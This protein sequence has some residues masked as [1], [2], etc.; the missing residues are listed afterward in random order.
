MFC[1]RK[2]SVTFNAKRKDTKLKQ[3][4]AKK[5]KVPWNKG[6]HM[7]KGKEH[8]RGTLGK[9]LP[10]KVVSEETK[11]KMRVVTK[12][13]WKEQGFRERMTGENANAWRGGVTS[14]NEAE[15][16][17]CKYK[18]WRNAVFERDSYT[19]QE[20]GKKG[21]FLHADHIKPFS[22]FK[23]LRFDINNGRTLCVD[24]HRR[25]ETYGGK[26]LVFAERFKI[27]WN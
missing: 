27:K 17:C 6:I 24:C 11:E 13:R 2:C 14:E 12:D 16:K 5:G 4:L 15:R 10:P 9:K 18:E 8:P 25:T 1:S 20:C 22:L 26:L 21:G 19:C 7:W 3:S 23:G